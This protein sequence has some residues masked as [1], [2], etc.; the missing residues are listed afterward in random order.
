MAAPA[1]YLTLRDALLDLIQRDQL[2][3]PGCLPAERW[4][5]EHF[6]TTRVTLRQALTQLE[7]EGVIYRQH[8]K[9]W[10]VAPKKLVYE[11]VQDVSF[12]RYVTAQGRVPQTE[13]LGFVQLAAEERIAHQLELQ[14]GEPVYRLIRRRFIDQRLVL[15]ERVWMN[16]RYLPQ[17]EQQRFD[18]SL[19][20]V[21]E[22]VYGIQL[23]DKQITLTPT[24]LQHEEAAALCVT[25]GSPGLY[26]TRRSATAQSEVIEY[27]E[28]Y[29]LQDVMTVRI[30][31]QHA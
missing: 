22:E 13:V 4:L 25:P 15:V 9:G 28:E 18:Q 7:S 14:P 5:A 19:W 10:F 24:A 27:D 30:T 1:F 26:I 31:T 3:R 21:F 23:I 17:L 11:P 16:A 8:R 6:Q 20:R 2:P 29:W 12:T